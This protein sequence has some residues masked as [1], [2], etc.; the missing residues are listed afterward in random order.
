MEYVENV[1]KRQLKTN[2]SVTIKYLPLKCY[3]YPS[4][5]SWL[6]LSKQT[7]FAMAVFLEQRELRDVMM[8][9]W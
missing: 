9:I 6:F 1:F 3:H 8:I 4:L 2:N 7:L 5:H